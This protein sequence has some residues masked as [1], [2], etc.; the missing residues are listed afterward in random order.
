V[1]ASVSFRTLR[2]KVRRNVEEKRFYCFFEAIGEQY[3]AGFG[4]TYFFHPEDGGD[5]F[6]RNVG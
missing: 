5:M 3:L 1:K 4:W 6:L 2:G